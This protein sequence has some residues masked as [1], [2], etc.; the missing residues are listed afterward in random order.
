MSSSQR[1]PGNGRF[2][3]ASIRTPEGLT[4]AGPVAAGIGECEAFRLWVDGLA[5]E[6]NE[7]LMQLRQYGFTCD[8]VT[9]AAQ[10]R[11]ALEAGPA[12][13]VSRIVGQR[14]LGLLARLP[15][16]GCFFLEE[17]PQASPGLTP[18]PSAAGPPCPRWT[19]RPA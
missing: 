18:A 14:L 15:P 9:L 10:L 19:G 6:G 1:R 5:P 12:G 8:L 2:L 17:G 11:R 3:L 7:A 4:P 16:E 13:P